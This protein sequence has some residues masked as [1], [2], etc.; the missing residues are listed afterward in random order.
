MEECSPSSVITH[1]P[2]TVE[3]SKAQQT[4]SRPP[5]KSMMSLILTRLQII[6]GRSLWERAIPRSWGTPVPPT[7]TI[8]YVFG[9][10][11]GAL[12]LTF[13]DLYRLCPT[14]MM[15]GTSLRQN[16]ESASAWSNFFYLGD[17]P[18]KVCYPPSPSGYICETALDTLLRV[19]VAN[20]RCPLGEH[21]CDGACVAGSG[22]CL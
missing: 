5:A 17:V 12:D 19:C 20:H 16:P 22:S 7:S 11:F 13:S 4:F 8:Y 10:D 21:F 3:H 6:P 14:N 15:T 1:P 2:I 9:P 18:H